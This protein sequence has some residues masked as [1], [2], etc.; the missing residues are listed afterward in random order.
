MRRR[1]FIAFVGSAVATRPRAARARPGPIPVPPIPPIIS[2]PISSA[3][4]YDQN[5]VLVRTIWSAQT[6]DPR[7]NNLST[8]WDGLLDN[9]TIAASGTYTIKLLTN[10]VQYN[11]DGVIG[12]TSPNHANCLY[13]NWAESITDMAISP[14][15]EMY[16]T[17]QYNER[18]VVAQVTTTVD[19]QTCR[20]VVPQA[21]RIA[22]SAFLT[23]TD[24]TLA[25]FAGFN[26][27]TDSF[28]WAVSTAQILP[29]NNLCEKLH[30]D[31]PSGTS[32]RFG[33]ITKV[34]GFDASPTNFLTQPSGLAVQQSGNYLFLARAF[35][36]TVMTI[37]K[38][39]GATLQTL[40]TLTN[41]QR[42]ATNPATGELWITHGNSPSIVVEKFTA[43]GTG[44]LSST[45][46]VIF[47]IANPQALAVSPDG[48]MLL[49]VD[50]APAHVVR[51][52]NTSDGSV[53]T[54]WATSGV[55]GTLGGYFNSPAVTLTKFCFLTSGYGA[56]QPWITFAP[57]GSFWL[58][59]ISNYRNLHFSSGNAPAYIEQIAYIPLFYSTRLVRGDN[60]RITANF[61]EFKLNY[62]KPLGANNGSWTLTYNWLGNL[63]PDSYEY[64][65][66]GFNALQFALVASN[67]RTYGCLN[68]ATARKFYEMD[69]VHGL[70]DTGHAVSGGA[71]V[72]AS[73]NLY[74]FNNAVTGQFLQ[75][76]E[77]PFTG[78][79][80][81]NNPTWQF[82]DQGRGPLKWQS[83]A[84]M[85][86]NWIN[87]GVYGSEGLKSDTTASGLMIFYYPY[88]DVTSDTKSYL[89]GFDPVSGILKWQTHYGQ[90]PNHGALPGAPSFL[91]FLQYPDVPTAPYANGEGQFGGGILRYLSG[92]PNIFT[93]HHGEDWANNQTN[94]L[95]HWHESGLLVNRFG[96]LLQSQS[97][98]YSGP[99]SLKG[100]PTN[101]NS[102]DGIP[103][104]SP[105]S[106]K[107]TPGFAGNA[108]WGDVALVDGVY[109][110]YQNDEW[111]HG[112]IHRWSIK[113]ANSILLTTQEVT[114]N[115]NYIPPNDP[116]NLLQGLP[117]NST[118]PNNTAGWTR[119]PASD[120][121]S[122]NPSTP[123]LWQIYT[124]AISCDRFNPDIGMVPFAEGVNYTLSRTIPA[125]GTGDWTLSGGVMM[126]ASSILGEYIPPIIYEAVYWEIVDAN[127]KIIVRFYIGGGDDNMGRW[128]VNDI[129]QS[130]YTM[131]FSSFAFHAE[132][133]QP[134][135][136]FSNIQSETIKINWGGWLASVGIYQAGADIAAPANVV[137][138]YYSQPRGAGNYPTF[139]F[140]TLRWSRPH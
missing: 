13:H 35:R 109:H 112:G 26:G 140:K 34:A 98:A 6:N 99:G 14:A 115:G 78:F 1:E 58:G 24:G 113:N 137:L 42:I 111:Y 96:T 138:T 87:V 48:A 30:Y 53:R 32:V 38:T 67:G 81:S 104:S 102:P 114:W 31:F 20:P 131:P 45:G 33:V 70:R 80:G 95:Y 89:A 61:L 132:G 90:P 68:S 120:I 43:D 25:Y 11:W 75:I 54:T 40:T 62:S 97:G 65:N 127:S 79:D 121:W 100:D 110:V 108:G 77:N 73:L 56:V 57:D 29:A 63:A 39:S 18:L 2:G 103:I 86:A 135:T 101:I 83:A 21:F 44:N 82:G 50:A 69:P 51:A 60:T 17:T 84:P 52:F 64:K 124:N 47:G 66:N 105:Y 118:V 16:F 3:G 122:G 129:L 94:Q 92:D 4:V 23:C 59:D 55:F 88:T 7:V 126:S 85:P 123:P 116:N 9:G 15:G 134:F 76:W 125:G 139:A 136:F 74:Q 128:W 36:H 117:Y 27:N 107:A 72:D 130:A 93:S 12:N 37:D 5:D 46:V 119:N 71:Y 41:P 10:D 19:P 8:A 22:Y 91:A 49:V 106:W 133:V 28:A